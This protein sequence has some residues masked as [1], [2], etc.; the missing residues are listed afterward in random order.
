[1]NIWNND[2]YKNNQIKL[3]NLHYLINTFLTNTILI[4][5][6]DLSLNF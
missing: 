5:N 4:V 1:M 6:H 2:M 3:K